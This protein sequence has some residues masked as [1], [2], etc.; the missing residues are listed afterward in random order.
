MTTTKTE[1]PTLHLSRWT[2][3]SGSQVQS[4]GAVVISS[5]EHQW[6][7]SAEGNGAVDAL[8]RAVDR[9]LAGVL[10]GHPRLLSYDVH[11]VA[12]GP[13]SEGVVTVRI[14]PPS[15]ATGRRGT[16]SY[17]GEARSENIIAASVDAYID[18][19]NRLLAEAHWAGAAD[20]AG[21]RKRAAA[22]A[23]AEGRR[24]ELDP[25]EANHDTT[26]WFER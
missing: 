25:D 1:T 20:S 9:A 2:V 21:N 5:G 22:G 24:A 26:A 12:E 16:G 14:A 19:I 15:G 6:K 7:A 17:N 11:A 18:A 10:T 13:D 4:R 8:Y 3:T 23:A